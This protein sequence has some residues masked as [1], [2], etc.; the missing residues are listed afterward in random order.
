LLTTEKVASKQ[1]KLTHNNIEKVINLTQST[2]SNKFKIIALYLERVAVNCPEFSDW[3]MEWLS[4]CENEETR[5]KAV[6]NSV[7]KIKEFTNMYLDKQNI[8]Y[9]HFVDETKAKKNSI[10]F[11]EDDLKKI[12]QLSCYLKIFSLVTITEEFKIGQKLHRDVY[13]KLASEIAETTIVRKIYDVVKTRTFRYNQTDKF[14]WDYIK[15]VQCKD[16]GTHVVAI[17]NFILN[18]ILVVCE[19]TKNPISYFVGVIDESIKWFLLDV[20]KNTIVYE[21]SIST[22]DVQGIN[23]DNLKSYTFNDTLGRLKGIAYDKIYEV[24]QKQT[25][26]PS[27]QSAATDLAIVEFHERA[28]SI[29]FISPLSETL[30]YPILSKCLEIPYNHFKIISPE[31]SA[32]ISVYVYEVLKKVFGSDY[33]NLFG[34][35]QYYP[36]KSPAIST[37]YK[38][39]AITEYIKIQ[40][41]TKNFFGFETKIL[42]HDILCHFIGR[43]SRV[44]F[45][46]ILDGRKMGGI[47]LSKIEHDMI[48]FYTS[49]FAGKLDDKLKEVGRVIDN[50][51]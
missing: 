17:F 39:K 51:F 11:F 36:T 5:S 34:L 10:M 25:L 29:Q 7:A 16:I 24:I 47:P 31:H 19:E 20:Y 14:M 43:I 44:D 8:D 38:I 40:D 21:D 28:R 1:W 30:V 46:N 18:H 15:T 4:Q 48:Y 50:D 23:I 9:S 41:E 2:T 6:A 35:L 45:C 42:P 12:I 27:T 37:T 26:L 32:V 22:E 49:Y 3:F 13:N 33:K